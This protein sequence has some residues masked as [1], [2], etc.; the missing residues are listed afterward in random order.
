M[1][2]VFHFEGGSMQYAILMFFQHIANPVLDFLAQAVTFCGET[3]PI[4]LILLF[5]Y[6]CIDKRKGFGTLCSLVASTI[7]FNILK[8]IFRVPRPFWKHPEIQGKRTSTATG[9]SFPSGHTTVAATIYPSIGVAFNKRWIFI[10]G[11]VIAFFIGLSRNYLGVHW[12][13]DVIVGY[14]L[15]VL[16]AILITPLC[17]KF[18]DSDKPF[19]YISIG[20]AVLASI[21]AIVLASL[22]QW[23]A[24]DKI[25]V[26][27]LMKSIA[28][29]GG[30]FWGILLE[31]KYVKFDTTGL[32]GRKLLIFACGFAGV[33]IIM[34]LKLIIPSSFTSLGGCIRYAL[35]GFWGTGLFP[36][37]GTKTGLMDT[38]AR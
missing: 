34:M 7:G 36:Y 19:T 11:L 15:G 30:A 25:A 1:Q 2:Y 27:D 10:A 23:T 14:I 12:P 21:S 8:A 35:T 24:I 22:M 33:G 26:S 18:Y 32:W 3:T 5:T 20:I 37:I 9:Y 38:E 17:I 13:L 16:S 31:K 4:I 29:T 28:L 6:W